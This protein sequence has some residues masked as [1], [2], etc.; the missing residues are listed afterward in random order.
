MVKKKT[1]ITTNKEIYDNFIL[2]NFVS[3]VLLKNV[4]QVQITRILKNINKK[5]KILDMK[6]F[7]DYIIVKKLNP[8]N[9][10]IYLK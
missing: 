2:L 7:D 9:F 10:N 3:E 8:L 4:K 1:I 5:D 6:K